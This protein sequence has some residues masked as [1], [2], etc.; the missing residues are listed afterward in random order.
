[1]L[2]LDAGAPVEV[3]VRER[4]PAG[5]GELEPYGTGSKM[6]VPLREIPATVNIV[7]QQTLRE[8][9]IVDHIQALEQLPGVVPQWTYGGFQYNQMRGFQALTLFDG[10]RDSRMTKG[11]N[12]SAPMTGLFDVDR[13]EVL[14]G[15]SAVLYGF[16]AVGGV[17]NTIRKRASRTPRYE[18]EGGLG[19]PH[20]WLAHASAQGPIL[21]KVAYRV[22]VGHVT[23]RDFR[24]IQ[25]QRNQ[26]TSTFQY[27]PTSRDTLNTRV[28]VAVDH[29]DTDLGLPTVEDPSRPGRWVLPY[30]SRYTNNYGTRNDTF[31]YAR[32]EGAIDYRHDFSQAVF[33]EVRGWIVKDRYEYLAAEGLNYVPAAGMQR[34]QV[35]RDYFSFTRAWRPLQVSAELHADVQTGPLKHQLVGGYQLE[36]FTGD[37]D[38]SNH[39]GATPANVD[40]SYPVDDS[41]PVVRNRT[42][43]D[44]YRVATHSLYAFD[45][46]KL[47]DS[48]ILTGGVR[49][50]VAKS[51]V[52]RE[53]NDRDGNEI[54]EA[55]TGMLRRPNLETDN[56]TTG[57]A[58][59]VYTPLELLTL[60]VSYGNSYKPNFVQPGERIPRDYTPER[61]QQFEGGLR[62]RVDQNKQQ[63]E[64]DAAGYLIRKRNLLVPRG[65][66]AFATAGLAESKGLD[67]SVRYAVPYVQ[68]SGGYSLT[69][70]H[71][72]EYVAPSPITGENIDLSG[73]EMWLAPRHSG[74][75]WLR[76]ALSPYLSGGVGT[77][78][79]G[80]TWADDANRLL[81]PSFA[82]LDASITFGDERASFTLRGSNL[83]NRVDYFTSSI[84]TGSLNPQV[85]PGPG[86]E[87]LGTL[88]MTL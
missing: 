7:D 17:I 19:S 51:R 59:I 38:S 30:G 10:R 3:R 16:G 6:N 18:L 75:A 44:H 13:I 36:S 24:G 42:R 20:A 2:G 77:R 14:R 84:N 67:L 72:L 60:Y 56:Q 43:R 1:M 62:V 48:L 22:D 21:G 11:I 45:H 40:F 73:K 28:S 49:F 88:R 76:L 65:Q 26:V 25:T 15:P 8:R 66:D 80:R 69:D 29:Y 85:T 50:D 32:I 33:A 39:D 41:P 71:Y 31:D 86:R 4:R 63:L 68:L 34:A 53:F 5:P 37:T 82:L 46:L 58:G 52:R 12:G 70:A 79:R 35:S 54:P 78:V 61:S 47:L 64:L 81:L 83:L 9:G 55:S 23:R 57:S 87:I 27:K 74:T